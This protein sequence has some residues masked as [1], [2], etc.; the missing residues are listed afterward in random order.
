M[1]PRRGSIPRQTD[2]LTVSRNMTM[3]YPFQALAS[4]HPDVPVSFCYFCYV[5][6]LILHHMPATN[7]LDPS[8]L[9][10]GFLPNIFLHFYPIIF[11]DQQNRPFSGPS[12]TPVLVSYWFAWWSC[13]SPAFHSVPW[14]VNGNWVPHLHFLSASCK[15]RNIRPAGY[16]GSMTHWHSAL[17]LS[18][19]R[20]KV[21]KILLRGLPLEVRA[22]MLL[23]EIKHIEYPAIHVR[24]LRRTTYNEN[25]QQRNSL[26]LPLHVIT[27]TVEKIHVT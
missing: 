2:W 19:S 9:H 10:V 23:S 18:N 4:L 17:K 3:T 13:E 1:S 27:Y 25:L 8:P 16:S 6:S 5:F 15:I 26:F 22:W 7:S 12:Y 21:H 11:P 24:Q 14:R 20:G